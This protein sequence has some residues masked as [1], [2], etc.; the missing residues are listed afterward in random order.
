M[1]I[2]IISERYPPYYDGGYEI[3]CRN[4]AEG[5]RR[6]GHE[7]RVL[8]STYR[9]GRPLTDG[10]VDRRLHRYQDSPSLLRLAFWERSD[11][12][13]LRTA[14]ATWNPDVVYVWCIA[15]LFPSL[16]AVL[17]AAHLPVAY[18]LQDLWIP[19]H[20]AWGR[21]YAALWKRPG[22]NP[23]K[24]L[25]KRCIVGGLSLAESAWLRTPELTEIPLDAVVFC[26]SEL[27]AR[28]LA[29]GVPVRNAEVI[30]NSVDLGLFH[31]PAQ[32]E[33][34]SGHKLLFVGRLVQEKGAHV[35]VAA[36]RELLRR[37]LAVRLDVAGVPCF[38]L[39]YAEAIER[40][41]AEVDLAASVRLLGRVDNTDLAGVFRAGDILLFPS[42]VP[43]GLPVTILEAMASG[44]AVVAT[45][46]G[47]STDFLVH[48][49]NCLILRSATD[50]LELADHVERLIRDDVLRRSLARG[51]LIWVQEN[52]SLEVVA[53]R[54]ERALERLVEAK[55][56][57]AQ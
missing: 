8:T 22:S 6:R 53:L 30:Y 47:G 20:L 42:G 43:E 21:Q 4:A 56:S 33:V 7:V 19:V 32:S 24:T 16:H 29:A 11:I 17:E 48:E 25:A 15:Q 5:L 46:K 49:S 14:L 35:A 37:G 10:H 27:R 2:L 55:R 1:R 52:C 3:A 9:V 39:S 44:L 26:G 50:A 57:A 34:R 41:A 38:P 40:S 18:A 36:V 45:A 28:H 12:R 54:T 23:L 13:Y 31:P 51:A